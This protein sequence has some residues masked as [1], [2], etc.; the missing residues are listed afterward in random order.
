MVSQSGRGE[1]RRRG[2]GADEAQDAAGARG[3]RFFQA[4][5]RVI[6]FFP[7]LLPGTCT[8]KQY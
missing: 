3:R 5:D 2:S 4:E 1:L 7:G 6:G 8:G